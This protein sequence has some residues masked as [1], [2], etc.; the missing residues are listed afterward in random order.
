M[1]KNEMIF[2]VLGQHCLKA[3]LRFDSL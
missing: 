1:A 3:F 2:K